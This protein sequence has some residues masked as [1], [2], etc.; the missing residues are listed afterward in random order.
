[1]TAQPAQPSIPV[2]AS[3]GA[4]VQSTVMLLMALRGEIGPRPDY[5]VFANTGAEPRAVYDHLVW[6][7][8][9]VLRLGG[10]L[11][12]IGHHETIHDWLERYISHGGRTPEGRGMLRPVPFFR[13]SDGAFPRRRQCTAEWKIRPINKYIRHVVLGLAHRQRVGSRRVVQQIGISLDEAQRMKPNREKYI[14][15][16]WP[17]ID[18]GMT[19]A[20]CH[21]WYAERYPGRHLPRSACTFCPFKSRAE[22]QDMRIDSPAEWQR[23]LRLDARLIENTGHMIKDKPLAVIDAE[24]K[25]KA[26]VLESEGLWGNDCGGGCGL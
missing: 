9:E 3:I 7:R 21:A 16:T 6:L 20:D 4:G 2:V 19:R 23:L 17:L 8:R 22:L 25:S 5:A 15:N 24:L 12:V 10:R 11:D 13:A 18:A 1:M 14:D 26:Q